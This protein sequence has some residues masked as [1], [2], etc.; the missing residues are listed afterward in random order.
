LPGRA[1]RK[2]GPAGGGNRAKAFRNG[3]MNSEPKRAAQST[4]V[5]KYV[6]YTLGHGDSLRGR[7][8][9]QLHDGRYSVETYG[10]LSGTPGNTTLSFDA[11]ADFHLFNTF[12]ETAA[13]L[14]GWYDG[15]K[16][17]SAR[18]AR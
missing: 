9:K 7:V 11:S 1:K 17:P 15:I 3:V 5:G 8:L 18:A 13:Y 2:P 16:C 14:C 12:D 4:I 6:V 10:W